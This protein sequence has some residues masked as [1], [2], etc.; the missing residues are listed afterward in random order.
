MS[1]LRA[2]ETRRYLLRAANTGISAFFDP[3]GNAFQKT[4]YKTRAA[5]S[6]M[7]YLNDK[8]TFYTK[9]GDYLAKI[10]LGISI[11]ILGYACIFSFLLKYRN[12]ENKKIN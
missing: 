10:M 7:V 4:E 2:I 5:I 12:I 3:L 9:Y 11:L 6:Q 8:I 1:A